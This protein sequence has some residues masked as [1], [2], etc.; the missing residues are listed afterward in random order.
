M[1][2]IQVVPDTVQAQSRRQNMIRMI[3][4]PQHTQ[5]SFHLDKGSFLIESLNSARDVEETQ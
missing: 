5:S 3:Q 2:G 1:T 4:G